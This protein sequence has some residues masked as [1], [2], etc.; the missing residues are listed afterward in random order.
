VSGQTVHRLTA[1]LD[2]TLVNWAI[3]GDGVENGALPATVRAEQA[4]DFTCPD[5]KVESGQD[6][7]SAK[8][9]VDIL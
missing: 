4:D 6:A 5:V 8:G 9:L 2:E 3:S 1:E 7:V